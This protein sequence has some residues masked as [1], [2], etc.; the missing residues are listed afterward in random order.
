MVGGW[1]CPGD[2][3]SL[4]RYRFLLSLIDFATQITPDESGGMQTCKVGAILAVV[5]TNAYSCF[6]N[7]SLAMPSVH[8]P[9]FIHLHK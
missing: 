5:G 9:L 1:P 6:V 3:V 2:W 4:N 8:F 7:K